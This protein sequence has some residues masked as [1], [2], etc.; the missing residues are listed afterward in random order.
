MKK[1]YL[2][3]IIILVLS[4]PALMAQEKNDTIPKK[5]KKEKPV[6]LPPIHWNVIKF[7]PTPMLIWGDRRNITFAYERL[8]KKDMSLSL[9]LGYLLFPNLLSDTVANTVTIYN[10]TRTGV[11]AAFD[12]RYYPFSRNPRP[13]PDGLYIGGYASY[14]GMKFNNKFDILQTNNAQQGSLDAK[15]NIINFGF[16]LGYQFIF[17]KRV[18]LDLILFGPSYSIFTGNV[19]ISGDL[20]YDQIQNI[21]QELVDKFFNRFPYM[22]TVFDSDG[23]HFTGNKSK[24][25]TLLRYSVSVG[26][27]F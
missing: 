12:Y 1:I 23:L 8:I 21:D 20:D 27:R 6:P 7:N 10:R 22:K 17:W 9:Q 26:F 5:N 2:V 19:N 25:T 15:L 3:W 4:L 16:E 24:I 13:A 11:N 18:S 14:Y